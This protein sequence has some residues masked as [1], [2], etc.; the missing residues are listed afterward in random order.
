MS[1]NTM[2]DNQPSDLETA[3]AYIRDSIRQDAEKAYRN[4]KPAVEEALGCVADAINRALL[5]LQP[6][7]EQR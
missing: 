7:Q 4:N 6:E 3:L 2:S 1:A 5:T